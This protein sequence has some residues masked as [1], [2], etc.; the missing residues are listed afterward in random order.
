MKRLLARLAIGGLTAHDAP[1]GWSV[2]CACRSCYLTAEGARDDVACESIHR[3]ALNLQDPP[4]PIF[5]R[6]LFS[7]W[8]T[9][10]TTEWEAGRSIVIH[11][12]AGVSRAP[13]L[14]LLFCAKV[15]GCVPDGSFDEA[16]D[17]FEKLY[18]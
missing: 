2:A 9:W 14:A 11:D 12:D 1:D 7:R 6:E 17:G 18:D 5:P 4:I 16:W 3:I 10:A 8:L 13:S 15:L